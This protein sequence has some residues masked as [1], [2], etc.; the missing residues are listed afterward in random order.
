MPHPQMPITFSTL[1]FWHSPSILCYLNKTGILINL[2]LV[3]LAQSEPWGH[4]AHQHRNLL[5]AISE[6]A[7]CGTR[8][9]PE[10]QV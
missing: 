1:Q 2:F 10:I 4:S 3:S 8:L 9:F 5:V 6:I 7:E